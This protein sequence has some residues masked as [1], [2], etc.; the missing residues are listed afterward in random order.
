[1]RIDK[2][3]SNN[4]VYSRSQI[5]KLIK[6]NRIT[7]NNQIVK[8][9]SI[10]INENIDIIKINNETIKQI[11]LIYIALN[12]PE[13]YLCT[14]KITEKNPSIISLLKNFLEYDLHIIGRLDK[15]TTGLV[16]LT[17]D[18][19]FTHFL[20]KPD[21]NIEKEYEV[22][23]NDEL[24]LDKINKLNKPIIMDGKLLKEI[25]FLNLNFNKVN[26]VI[27]EG[28][29][30]QIKRLFRLVG[31]EVIKLNRIRINNLKLDNLN[32]EIGKYIKVEKRDII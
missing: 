24:T 8:I 12:K 1:M 10:N 4:S 25:I 28:K 26:V 29:Y 18:G 2:F 30:H 16:I 14:N 5:N 20:K 31:L 22:V 27:K 3:L 19:Q 17:N 13:N 23:L 21:N 9:G 7:I 11:G 32:I 6:E 15:N